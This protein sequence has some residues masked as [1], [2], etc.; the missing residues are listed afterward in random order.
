M[1]D[2]DEA[3]CPETGFREAN[4]CRVSSRVKEA[5]KTCGERVLS[6]PWSIRGRK[7]RDWLTRKIQMT[8]ILGGYTCRNMISRFSVEI[9]IYILYI[10]RSMMTCRPNSN[11]LLCR[12][13]VHYVVLWMK[14]DHLTTVHQCVFTSKK[15]EIASTVEIYNLKELILYYYAYLFLYLVILYNL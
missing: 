13:L 1:C 15:Y 10:L 5:S 14:E 3:S 8:A 4:L 6:C 9:D 12:L 7:K 11:W 2:L